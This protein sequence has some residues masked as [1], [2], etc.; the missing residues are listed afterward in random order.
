MSCHLAQFLA[1][2]KFLLLD[3]IRTPHG[4]LF[5]HSM[6]EVLLSPQISG[7]VSR[8]D[9]APSEQIAKLPLLHPENRVLAKKPQSEIFFYQPCYL[10]N[11]GAKD[12]DLSHVMLHFGEAHWGTNPP[13]LL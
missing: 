2:A 8:E 3:I 9:K 5:Y 10:S 7:E 4:Q 13:T 12:N 1:D 6:L 11:L